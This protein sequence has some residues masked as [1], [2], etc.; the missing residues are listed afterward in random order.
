MKRRRAKLL[1]D[2]RESLLPAANGP[3]EL[4]TTS[5]FRLLMRALLSVAISR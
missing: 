5:F 4:K 3:T 2:F 1:N